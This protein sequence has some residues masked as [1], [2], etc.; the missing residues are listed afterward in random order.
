[1]AI[2]S[3]LSLATYIVWRN[4]YDQQ[5]LTQLDIIYWIQ[6]FLF[7]TDGFINVL[8]TYLYF[9]FANNLYKCCCKSIHYLI[10]KCCL[11]T[12]T[13][14]LHIEINRFRASQLLEMQLDPSN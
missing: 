5:N 4:V 11:F 6:I 3:T 2:I 9:G 13:K 8:S 14:C 12:N 7:S 10:L 1:M